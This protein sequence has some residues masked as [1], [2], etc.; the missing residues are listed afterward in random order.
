[1]MAEVVDP[2]PTIHIRVV[3]TDGCAGAPPTVERIRKT[4]AEM[5]LKISL[6]EA[7][8]A[9]QAEADA[10]RML[11]SPTVQ[12]NGL[13]LDPTRRGETRYSFT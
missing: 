3:S 6:E 11:G 1:V 5:K 9:T 4:A 7:V 13:D 8:V 12:I 2:P 10:L